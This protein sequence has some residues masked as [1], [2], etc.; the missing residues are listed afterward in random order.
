MNGERPNSA[1]LAAEYG[2]MTNPLSSRSARTREPYKPEPDLFLKFASVDPNADAEILSFANSYGLLGGGPRWIAP[3]PKRKGSE[4]TT[5]TGEVRSHWQEHLHRM[6]AAV[7]LWVA[8]QG[9][10]SSVLASCIRWR[11]RDHVTYDWPPSSELTTPW[12][13]H[14]TIASPGI[15]S[16]LLKRFRTRRCSEAGTALST[17]SGQ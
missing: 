11:S 1:R 15:N 17:G 4:T 12:S 6:K 16:H 9:E 5:V 3:A 8:I 2:N 13:T 14:A 7:T 10:D